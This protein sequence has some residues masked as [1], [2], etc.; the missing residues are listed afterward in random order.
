MLGDRAKKGGSESSWNVSWNVSWNFI[1]R[2]TYIFVLF[3]YLPSFWSFPPC[4]L[5]IGNLSYHY[6]SFIYCVCN[7]LSTSLHLFL[8]CIES[9]IIIVCLNFRF[10]S[11]DILD[12]SSL[13]NMVLYL[14]FSL[15]YT[16]NVNDVLYSVITIYY[17]N[18]IRDHVYSVCVL[19]VYV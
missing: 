2:A 4:C 5:K 19:R 13:N 16:M 9:I 11:L 14:S 10:Y 17:M 8:F 1:I 15:L 12:R 18:R 3:K 7:V 6:V